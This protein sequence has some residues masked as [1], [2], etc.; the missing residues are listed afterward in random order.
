MDRLRLG[1][2]LVKAG[3]ITEQMLQEALRVQKEHRAEGRPAEETLIGFILVQLEYATN[4]QVFKYLVDDGI[5]V[6]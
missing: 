1:E 4:D 6:S 5:R 2:R 3:V